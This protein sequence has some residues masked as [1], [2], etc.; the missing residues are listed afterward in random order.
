MLH[1]QGLGNLVA[2][3]FGLAAA[4]SDL[5]EWDRVVGS[6]ENAGRRVRIAMVGKYVELA[7]SYKSLSEA[8]VHAGIHTGSRVEILYVDSEEIES[9]GADCLQGAHA[10]LVPGG[11][12]KRGS[13]ARSGPR[14]TRARTR[15]PISASASG[16]RS[17]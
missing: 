3:R 11:F 4:Q 5:S 16:C 13:K 7:E 17:R 14:A 9:A 8:L 12:G 15:C 10:V 2:E 1:E 6:I